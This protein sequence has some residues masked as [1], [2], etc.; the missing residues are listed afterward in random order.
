[1]D[2]NK[3]KERKRARGKERKRKKELQIERDILFFERQ[4][5][6]PSLTVKILNGT[7]RPIVPRKKEREKEKGQKS[8]INRLREY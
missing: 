5:D 3:E 1:M 7:P 8:E 2:K 6:N 4:P